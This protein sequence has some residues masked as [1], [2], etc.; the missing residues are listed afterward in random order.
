M[1]GKLKLTA[2]VSRL[3]IQ[4]EN[5]LVAVALDDFSIVLVELQCGRVARRFDEAHLAP[6]LDLTFNSTGE[7]LISCALD[8]SLKVWDLPTGT[9]VDVLMVSVRIICG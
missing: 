4:G 8:S 7:W 3:I 5:D 6:I 2:G 1:A 9:L